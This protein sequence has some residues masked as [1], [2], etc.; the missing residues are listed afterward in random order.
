MR[1]DSG[2]DLRY[3]VPSFPRTLPMSIPTDADLNAQAAAL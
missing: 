2:A 3:N 1:R